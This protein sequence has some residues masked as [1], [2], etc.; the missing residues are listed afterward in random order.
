MKEKKGYFVRANEKNEDFWLNTP[1]IPDVS[2]E[3][4]L[5]ANLRHSKGL[6]EVTTVG[7]PFP[8]PKEAY[9]KSY[10]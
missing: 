4:H 8:N 5:K 10:C 1:W 2:L 9:Q 3:C 7:L 6:Y